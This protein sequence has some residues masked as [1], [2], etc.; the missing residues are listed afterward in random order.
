[1]AVD[2]EN[3]RCGVCF[4]WGED[5][6]DPLL[7]CSGCELWAHA[8]CYGPQYMLPT[9]QRAGWASRPKQTA[10][11]L[12]ALAR[13]RPAPAFRCCVCAADLP[14]GVQ[15][16]CRVCLRN[17]A[18]RSDASLRAAKPLVDADPALV[19]PPPPGR[20]SAWV[21]IS[22]ALWCPGAYFFDAAGKDHPTLGDAPGGGGGGAARREARC[23]VCETAGRPALGVPLRC[24]APGCALTFHMICGRELGW[25]LVT[26]EDRAGGVDMRVFCGS[27]STLAHLREVQDGEVTACERCEKGDRP[28]ELLICEGCNKGWHVGCATP[29]L[30]AVPAGDWFCGGCAA[31]RGG[32]GR[33]VG[34]GGGVGGGGGNTALHAPGGGAAAAAAAV[35]AA[36]ATEAPAAAAAS[37]APAAAAAAAAADAAGR[38]RPRGVDAEVPNTY[39]THHRLL[40][41]K[42]PPPVPPPLHALLEAGCGDA[43]G[44]DP[45][46]LAWAAAGAR[47]DRTALLGSLLPMLRGGGPAAVTVSSA[48]DPLPASWSLAIAFAEA[49]GGDATVMLVDLGV[50]GGSVGGAPGS[51]MGGALVAY[52][53]GDATAADWGALPAAKLLV[54]VANDPH[55]LLAVP[56]GLL[57]G[58]IVVRVTWQS[59]ALAPPPPPLPAHTTHPLHLAPFPFLP[60][61]AHTAHPLH[62]T[63]RRFHH[64]ARSCTGASTACNPAPQASPRPCCC[65]RRVAHRVARTACPR[66]CAASQQ[67]TAASSH[68]C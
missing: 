5:A 55:D 9:K 32:G 40:T 26:Q 3:T 25:E 7:R 58:R 68:C 15:R 16:P 39:F 22:C 4:E 11:S 65:T 27:H 45:T 47:A 44:A 38:K 60:S 67:T 66:C 24:A 23:F 31:A 2:T 1:M 59:Q 33:G 57:F 13:A 17:V 53:F 20:G 48:G 56:A 61:R 50:R 18:G 42:D 54:L 63:H 14:A 28:A 35:A 19:P 36:V 49:E 34:V 29:P 12:A 37:A 6:D 10:A 30:D 51:L 21:H 41:L 62:P 46:Q 8:H 43:G 52:N 64:R